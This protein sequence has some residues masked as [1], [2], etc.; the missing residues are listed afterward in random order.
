L[1]WDYLKILAVGAHPDDVELGSGGAL[2]LYKRKGHQVYVLVLTRGE[3]SGDPAVREDECKLAAAAIG[4]D[5]LSFGDLHDTR[6]SDGIETISVIENVIDAVAPDVVFSHNSSDTH[7]DHRNASLASLSASRRVRKVFLYE[8][9]AALM[10]MQGNAFTPQVF[11]DIA[12]VIDLKLK[13][14]AAF[15]SQA[16]KPYVNGK[17]CTSDPC[18]N[19][20]H[21]PAL[22][23]MIAGVARFRGFQA[24]LA[25]AEAFEV[26]REIFDIETV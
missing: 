5:Q 4:V 13:A 7:Q 10:G 3:A 1:R 19:C 14:I 16:S 21:H 20:E 23:N 26:A 22:S 11:I 2:A 17:P 12:P 8:S 6:I 24:G 25:F 15:N 18:I 9:P